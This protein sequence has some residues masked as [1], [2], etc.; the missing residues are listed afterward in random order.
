MNTF[1]QKDEELRSVAKFPD[2][3]PNPIMR[4]AR[5]GEILY[6]NAASAPLLRLFDRQVGQI[7]PGSW[8]IEVDA[9]HASAQPKVLEI[10]TG[11]RVF[12]CMLTPIAGAGYVNLYGHDVTSRKAAE[13]E[14]Q[15]HRER[16]EDL[17][18]ERTA[19][20]EANNAQLATEIMDRKHAEEE[21]RKLSRVVEQSPAT[22][23]I[24]N[25]EGA[26]E[27][28]NPKFVET[29]GYTREEAVGQTPRVLKSGTHPPAFYEELWRKI[30]A[31]N[32]WH[33]EFCNKK[34]NGELYFESAAI[35]PIRN[36]QGRITHFVAIKEDI[37]GQRRIAD[38][39]RNAKDAAEAANRA[40]SD[41]LAN[42]SHE[43]RTPLG[44]IIGFSELLEEKLFG[45]LN[46]K[47]EEYV[48]DILESGRHLLSVINDI[49]DLAKVEAGKM[50][51]ELSTFPLGTLLDNS[52]VMVREKCLKQGIALSLYIPEPIR[53]L[54]ISADE[55]KLKQI[56]FNLLSNA[57]KFTPEAG[58]ITVN[59]K[60]NENEVLV[61]VLDT[62]SG[63]S[64]KHQEPVF[65]EFYQTTG[66]EKGK[67]PGTGL[68]LSLVRR[69]VELHGGR[70][71]VESEGKGSAFRFTLPLQGNRSTPAAEGARPTPSAPLQ[72]VSDF[73][74]QALAGAG[75]FCLCRVEP[76]D[77]MVS[78]AQAAVVQEFN[79]G[80]RE[81]DTA[82]VD[83][84]G[85]FMLILT[86]TDRAGAETALG[87][88]VARLEARLGEGWRRAAAVCPDD[89]QTL[90]AL[91]EVLRL[92]CGR[93]RQG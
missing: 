45:D 25:I 17:V 56:M 82:L 87:R 42:M 61:S 38:E 53:D 5:A 7:L 71:W 79:K 14:L 35:T 23:I 10:Q 1:L 21:L 36:E 37:T 33:G 29:T 67:A 27:Y 60:R 92:R 11:N 66:G 2:E 83:E 90:E 59:A 24:T 78:V 4:I 70:V 65:D 69:M 86:N 54:V 77:R 75:R 72:R 15:R 68:G 40:K 81:N 28:V 16:M 57:V 41:F 9:V 50:A 44:A 34:K 20:L 8:V 58:A 76:T 93:S 84:D 47:Q 80:K 13:A 30:R 73:V 43:L 62:G 12:A 85:H 48:R 39:L 19:A 64:K 22:V 52:L 32:V 6:A 88:L 63:I 89:G 3:N 74:A 26:I 31:G 91:M 51:L 46:L 18:K 55:R 49:L